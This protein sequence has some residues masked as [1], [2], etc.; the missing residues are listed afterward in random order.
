VRLGFAASDF[1]CELPQVIGDNEDLKDIRNAN[2]LH[3]GSLAA[4][5]AATL[6][7]GQHWQ[8]RTWGISGVSTVAWGLF[9]DVVD[10]SCQR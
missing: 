3:C 1:N 7:K 2:W 4:I 8:S 10:K 5:I 6:P 9:L